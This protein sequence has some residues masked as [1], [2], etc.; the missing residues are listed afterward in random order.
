MALVARGLSR[1]QR[2]DAGFTPDHALSMQLSLP[3]RV[4]TDRA[5]IEH[6]YETLRERLVSIPGVEYVGA[7]SLRPLSGLLSAMDIAFPDRPAPPPDEVPQAHFRVASPNYFAAAGIPIYAGREFTDRDGP[8]SQLVAVVSRTFA[9]RHW[10]GESGVGKSV[11]LVQSGPS[12]I[13]EVV[14]VV[15]DVKQ[16]TLEGA[17]TADLYVP[18]DQMPTSQE[19]LLASRLYWVLRTQGDPHSIAARVRHE[20][21]AVDPDVATSS[22]QTL[23]EII[24]LSLGAWR[25]NVR[26]LEVFGQVSVVLCAVGVYSVAAFSARIRR[27][28]LAIRTAFGASRRELTGLMLRDEMRPVLLGLALGSGAAF[29]LTPQLGSFLFGASPTDAPTHLVIGSI[30]AAVFVVGGFATYLPAACAA[31]SDTAELLRV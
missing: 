14:G 25:V 13:L 24:A 28:E 30:A 26:L 7:I 5:T 12:P 15:S 19:P 3:P 20:V 6:F 10:P 21:Q 16:F 4:Y 1:L 11:Q 22:I 2:V 23:D 8:R 31:S 27:R 9:Q 17:A 29:L 18:L